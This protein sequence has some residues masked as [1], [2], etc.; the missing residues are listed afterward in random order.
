[1]PKVDLDSIEQVNR[2]GYPPPFNEPVA[3]RWHRPIGDT[4]GFAELGARHVVLEPGAWSSQRHWHES[5]D[6]LLVMLSG[7]AVLVEDDGEQEVTVGDILAWP[8][9]SRNGHHLINRIDADPPGAAGEHG[10]GPIIVARQP[11]LAVVIAERLHVHALRHLELAGAAR[12]ILRKR[13]RRARGQAKQTRQLQHAP[14]VQ[15]FH[16]HGALLG[17]HPGATIGS[18]RGRARETAAGHCRAF[19]SRVLHRR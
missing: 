9:G 7:S 5:E 1:M 14:A 10:D 11:G 17:D 15:R 8:A 3:G 4:V 2:T 13:R 18:R 6:E 12:G 19:R 16:L